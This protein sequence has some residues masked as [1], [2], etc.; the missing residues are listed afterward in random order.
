MTGP[1]FFAIVSRKT[2]TLHPT[3]GIYTQ[4]H[5]SLLT[6]PLTHIYVSYIHTNTIHHTNVSFPI[7]R[8]NFRQ[9]MDNQINSELLDK[10]LDEEMIL[11]N[12][13]E[14]DDSL[15]GFELEENWENCH[16]PI[17][18]YSIINK[19]MDSSPTHKNQP[20]TKT[21]MTTI[22]SNVA[23]SS[24]H[25]SSSTSTT[26]VHSLVNTTTPILVTGHHSTCQNITPIH[27][28]IISK[29]NKSPTTHILL[30]LRKSTTITTT[31]A[32][33]ALP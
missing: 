19:L 27:T 32:S 4:L 15:L 13:D 20:Y 28:P 8:P 17:K 1:S 6:T 5:H 12:G 2:K 31:P 33:T 11:L 24:I 10:I 18:L 21:T 14:P 23:H 7:I 16:L 26:T 30:T 25:P 29:T 3:P 9:V 22:S